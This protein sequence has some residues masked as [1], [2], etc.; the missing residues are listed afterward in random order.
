MRRQGRRVFADDLDEF[1]RLHRGFQPLRASIGMFFDASRAVFFGGT[2]EPP[3]VASWTSF[4]REL[5]G[6]ERVP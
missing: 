1:V 3:A 2:G 6:A 4:C 5:V